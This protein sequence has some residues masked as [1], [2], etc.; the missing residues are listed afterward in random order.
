MKKLMV[1]IASAGAAIL[2]SSGLSCTKV[3]NRISTDD[4]CTK[5]FVTRSRANDSRDPAEKAQLLQDAD[6]YDQQCRDRNATM[7]GSATRQ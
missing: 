3:V 2:V 5:A 7:P 1:G 4:P 6:V